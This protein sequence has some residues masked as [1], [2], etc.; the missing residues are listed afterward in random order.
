MEKCWW[1][2][3]WIL[4]VL[5]LVVREDVGVVLFGVGFYLILSKCY[6]KIG[7]VVCIFSFVYMVV[8]INLIMLI[9][10]EDIF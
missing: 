5:I 2:L 8:L 1:F 10:F 7:L 4:V 9:F 3:F 6:F